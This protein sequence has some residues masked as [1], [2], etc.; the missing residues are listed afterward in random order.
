MRIFGTFALATALLAGCASTAPTSSAG[1]ISWPSAAD[2]SGLSA[3]LTRKLIKLDAAARASS[4]PFALQDD[5]AATESRGWLGAWDG[6]P[7]AY[8]VAAEN[9]QD[10]AHAVAFAR[11]HHLKLVVKGTGHDYLGRSN[12]PDS[13]LV[14]THPMRQITVQDAFVGHGC[15]STQ[16][17]VPV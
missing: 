8:A 11:E 14:W 2:W 16:P 4:N 17:G 13:L 1:P 10:V 9:A 7:R 5:P 15:P 6:K 3:Q 12:A